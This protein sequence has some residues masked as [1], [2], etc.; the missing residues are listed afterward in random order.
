MS[1]IIQIGEH[2][3]AIPEPKKK[4][5]ILFLDQKD[6]CWNRE[7]ALK[8][9]KPI[10]YDFVP[11]RDGTRLY[12]DA[13][14]Y[15]QDGELVSL[16][17]ED[18]DWI[19]WCYEREWYRR[20][21][22]VHFKNGNIIDYLT[23]DHWFILAWCKTKRPDKISDYFDFRY[24]QAEY[25]YL[26][27]HVN[28]TAIIDGLDLSKPKKTGITNIHWLYYLNKA[29]MTKNINCGNMNIDQGKGAKTFRD[30]FMYAYNGLPSPLRASI[31]T[32]SEADGIITFAER[33]NNSKK[34]RS[35]NAS[36]DELN[37]TVMCVPTMV[38][39]FDVDVFSDL[40]YDEPPKFTKDFGEIY[41][42]NEAGTNIQDI[43]VGKKWLTSYTPEGDAPSFLA[44][45]KI[46]YDSELRT[47]TPQSNGRTLT[48]LICHH[49][50][51]Y[52]SWGSSFDKHGRCNEIEASKK[53]QA[54]RDQLKD[55]PRELQAETRRYANTKREAWASG[56]AGSVFDGA[57]LAELLYNIEEEQRSSPTTPYLE[58]KLE[59][60]IKLW[61]LGLKNKRPKGQFC[62]VEFIPITDKELRDNK[63]G[64]LRIYNDIPDSQKNSILKSGR[65]EWGCI[66][67]PDVFKSFIGADPTQHA[68]ASEVIEGS[69]NA[70]YCMN[71]SDP[72]LDSML[73]KVSSGIITFEYF[74]R[75]ELPDEAYE[76][77]LKLIIY[78]GSLCTVEA[79]VPTMA[80]RLMEEGLGRFMMI[81]DKFGAYKI[82]E[83]WMGLPHEEEKEYHL[84]RTTSNNPQTREML[85]Y[86][87]RLIIGFIKEADSGEKDYGST[88]KSERL[89]DQLMRV[90]ITDTKIFDLFMAWGYCLFTQDQYSAIL[91]SGQNNN[92]SSV[93]FGSFM[94]AMTRA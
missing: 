23:G 41:R 32:K 35:K 67:P 55:K 74:D 82:W 15:N 91:L 49:I 7:E 16:N 51:A 5:E 47:I 61:E 9:Y 8:D 77:L 63:K 54:K 73:G 80:T 17:K 62:P 37:T 92:Q 50:P 79:N 14:L 78:T 52:Q 10:W 3:V 21:Y 88:L 29:T 26:I 93:S 59:W 76:D 33:V 56:G 85:E 45:K 24:F 70:Y 27:R 38:N 31:K 58:G 40:W 48:G 34:G 4:D 84:I 71:A 1:K 19:I 44:A 75:P 12:Q 20:T 11:G 22:G 13:T 60:T 83:R 30:H 66:I 6:P 90:D 65:D 36:D 87:V 69:K 42:S 89:V 81:K 72:R 53:I 2:A 86:F 25:L 64:R 39:A 57:R 43:S 18:S 46:F 68:A 94:Q 28:N